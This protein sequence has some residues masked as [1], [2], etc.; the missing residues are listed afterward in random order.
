[1][2]DFIYCNGSYLQKNQNLIA[3]YAEKV[4]ITACRHY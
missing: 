1:M 4:Y 3:N 2:Y